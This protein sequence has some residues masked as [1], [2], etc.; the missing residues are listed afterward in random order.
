MLRTRVKVCC[1]ANADE[2]RMAVA[3]GADAVGLVSAMPS[4]PGVISDALIADIARSVPPPVASFLLTSR[5]DAESI[6]GQHALCATTVLQ[7]CDHVP[8]AELRQLRARLPAVKLVQ[9]IHVIDEESVAE[10]LA[11]APLVDALLLDSGNQRLAVK[12]L[13][14]TGRTHDWRLSRRIREQCGLP[15]FLAGGLTPANVAEAVA[16][17]EPFGVD[18]CSGV[19]SDGRLDADKLRAFFAALGQG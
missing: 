12:E 17:V 11:A 9:V 10:A 16:A 5:V 18:L 7:L 2:A 19:R 15:L 8:H 4:G 3:A 1:I 13:G 14:G 6:I